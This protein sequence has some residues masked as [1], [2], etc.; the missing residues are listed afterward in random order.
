MAGKSADAKAQVARMASLSVAWGILAGV[1]YLGL[2]KRAV[3]F[4]KAQTSWPGF[5]VDG[6]L[7]ATN[8]SQVAA[9]YQTL[10]SVALIV[11]PIAAVA[12]IGLGIAVRVLP[13]LRALSTVEL[14]AALLGLLS[15]GVLFLDEVVNAQN[16]TQFLVALATIVLVGVLLRVQRFIR[17]F[18]RRAPA[19]TT[20]L[21]AVVTMAYLILSNGTSISAIILGQVHVWLAVIAFAI[22]FYAAVSQVR[23]GSRLGR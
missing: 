23:A 16:R 1:A 9:G 11:V 15:A 3:D 12:V 22:A 7:M 14:V 17:H 6:G 10:T 2:V 13:S 19:L 8:T 18:Y 5:A 21:F 20:L 4:A